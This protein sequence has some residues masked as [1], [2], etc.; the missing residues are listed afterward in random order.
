MRYSPP[1]IGGAV[2]TR[3]SRSSVSGQTTSLVCAWQRAAMKRRAKFCQNAMST[4]SLVCVKKPSESSPWPTPRSNASMIC[5]AMGASSAVPSSAS[6]RR[7]APCGFRVRMTDRDREFRLDCSKAVVSA[8]HYPAACQTQCHVS[9]A[10][11]LR[12]RLH[13]IWLVRTTMVE[14]HPGVATLHLPTSEDHGQ[15][16]IVSAVRTRFCPACPAAENIPSCR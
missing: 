15:A 13:S 12:D 2:S 11:S 10:R 4:G 14:N 1:R 6:S 8:R 7:N 16:A 5:V 3:L 9:L